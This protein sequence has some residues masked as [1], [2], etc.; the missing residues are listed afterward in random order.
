MVLWEVASYF[1]L[2]SHFPHIWVVAQDLSKLTL[3]YVFWK[4]LLITFLIAIIA[5]LLGSAIAIGVGIFLAT[6]DLFESSSRNIFNLLR[7]LPSVAILPLLIA[8]RGS[9]LST[10]LILTTFVVACKLLLFVVREIKYLSPALAEL[11][12]ILR[13]SWQLKLTR[14]YLPSLAS[15][16]GSG[17]I[18]AGDLAFVTVVLS[19]ILAGTPGIG[20]AFLRAEV[21][22]DVIRVFSYVIVMGLAGSFIFAFFRKL[23]RTL[24]IMQEII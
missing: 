9:S 8:Y 3:T 21:T 13:L 2:Q 23:G 7:S 17:A 15:L 11:T 18:L 1:A 10:V 19:G 4:S 20:S 16:L 24:K 14:V 5:F 22:G 6:H 12:A